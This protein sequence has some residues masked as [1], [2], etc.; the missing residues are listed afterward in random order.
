[1][2]RRT[3]SVFAKSNQGKLV[4]TVVNNM[5]ASSERKAKQ[6]KKDQARASKSN[7]RARDREQ[8]QREKR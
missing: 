7:E 8:K 4:G 1:M 5:L 2:A 6:A 3:R